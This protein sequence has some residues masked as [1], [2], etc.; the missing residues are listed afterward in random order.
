MASSEQNLEDF[1]VYSH[2]SDEELLHIA[3]DRSL[4]DKLTHADVDQRSTSVPSPPSLS[5]ESRPVC[6]QVLPPQPPQPVHVQNCANPPTALSQFL[7]KSIKREFSPIESIIM[8]GDAEALMDLVRKQ[9]GCLNESNSEGWIALHEAAHYGQ[10]QCVRILIRADPSSVNRCTLRNETALMLAARG[11]VS[12]VEFLL[13]HGASVNVVNKAKET[14]LFIACEHGN[15]DIV[16]LL[17]RYG[18]QVNLTCNQGTSALHEAC[19]YGNPRLCE[20]LL[21]AGADL[22]TKNIYNIQP[23]FTAAQHGNLEVLQLLVQRGA[24]I[25]AQAGDGASLLYEACKNGHVA[26][27]QFLLDLKAD[28][29]RVTGSG[30]LPLHVAVKNNHKRIVSLLIP[31]TSRVRVRTCG[32]SPLHIAAERNRDQIMELLIESGF[33]VNAK[34]SSEH[35]KMYEDRRRTALYFSVSNGNLEAAEML[36]QAGASPNLDTFNP[37]LIAV[38]LGWMDMAELLVGYGADVNTRMPT[39]S[40]TFPSAILLGMESLSILKLLL[41]HGCNAQLCFDCP[42]GLKPHPANVPLRRPIDELRVSE[43]LVPQRSI[44]YCEA[45]S[46]TS[47]SR[48][49]G[50]VISMLLDY[51]GHVKLCSRMIEV[52]E[53]RS[54]WIPIR[55][56]AL[57]VWRNVPKRQ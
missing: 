45:I 48:L 27:V 7:Y 29:N 9:A 18:A 16:E 42:Y 23:I 36:L 15:A 28:A 33:D 31:V 39:Q 35:S 17:L 21:D 5:S 3:V 13:K 38:R 11:N 46:S 57:Q 22:K 54:D 43:H 51:V 26:A 47:Y 10:L 12:C 44:Q 6:V 32:I 2:L 37:L 30:L 8:N 49:F 41:D 20:M 25:N 53:S 50:P 1:S 56:K 4:S 52:L 34:L 14:P 24:D 19:R 40:S 55:L